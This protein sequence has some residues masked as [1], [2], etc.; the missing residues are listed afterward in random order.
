MGL[1]PLAADG[2]AAAREAKERAAGRARTE[3]ATKKADED[4][5]RQRLKRCASLFAC[6]RCAA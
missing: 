4:E 2:G 1:K 5:L 6:L 3:A